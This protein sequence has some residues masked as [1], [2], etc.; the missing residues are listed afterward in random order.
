MARRCSSASR[1]WLLRG[2]A[3]CCSRSSGLPGQLRTHQIAEEADDLSIGAG[4]GGRRWGGPSGFGLRLRRGRF[5]ARCQQQAYQDENRQRQ[6][7]IRQVW[8]KDRRARMKSRAGGRPGSRCAQSRAPE[9]DGK[10]PFAS[11]SSVLARRKS[12]L[13]QT[14]KDEHHRSTAGQPP[15]AEI[16]TYRPAS[17]VTAIF[18]WRVLAAERRPPTPRRRGAT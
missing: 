5:L 11:A 4:G 12:A 14:E 13:G 15:T 3:W 8:P 17:T 7:G 6:G 18:R 9:L 1:I 16:C 10:A 2:C